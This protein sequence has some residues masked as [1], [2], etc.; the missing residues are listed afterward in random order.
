MI[1]IRCIERIYEIKNDRKV[2]ILRNQNPLS[3]KDMMKHLNSE[4]QE[5]IDFIENWEIVGQ[6]MVIISSVPIKTDI[7]IKDDIKPKT[8]EIESK[9]TKETSSVV[10]VE[11]PTPLQRKYKI[12]NTPWKDNKFDINDIADLWAKEGYD[13]KRIIDNTYHDFGDLVDNQKIKHVEGTAPKI[14]AVIDKNM[15]ASSLEKLRKEGV[16][17]IGSIQ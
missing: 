8:D 9:E 16:I 2:T 10:R 15:D 4:S 7:E 3:G 12:L 11:I 6:R 1:E 17:N 14:Y 13:R 5:L